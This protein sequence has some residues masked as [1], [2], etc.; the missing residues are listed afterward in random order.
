MSREEQLLWERKRLATWGLTSYELHPE[1]GRI[2]FPVASRL[3][4]CTDVAQNV[5]LSCYISN[6]WTNNC[7][8]QILTFQAAV[9]CP[10]ELD[11]NL[12]QTK[13]SPQICP[14]NPNLVAFVSNLDIWV[15]HSL[16]GRPWLDE[17]QRRKLTSPIFIGSSTRLTNYHKGPPYNLVDDP[18]SAGSPSYVMQEEFSRYQGYWWQPCQ[19]NPGVYRIAFELVDESEVDICCF[20]S[21][22][23]VEELRFP[24][25]GTPNAKS[26]LKMIQFR[27]NSTY[28]PMDVKIFNLT[29]SLNCLFPYYEYLVRVGWIPE[30]NQ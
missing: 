19:T 17:I 26:E 22:G 16:T 6:I 21:T 7:N 12:L 8:L 11:P 27:L 25:A 3:Y 10:T 30:G 1:S 28:K 18:L 14:S 5:C 13:L 29:R 20:P 4:Q 23:A 24:R 15:T 2:V 9:L